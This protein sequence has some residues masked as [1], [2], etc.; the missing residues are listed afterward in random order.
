M[1]RNFDAHTFIHKMMLAWVKD[2]SALGG[3]PA[4]SFAIVAL[5]ALGKISLA[6]YLLAAFIIGLLIAFAIR[7]LFPRER[8]DS[9]L[10]KGN[11]LE[12]LDSSSFPSVHSF[13]AT[14]LGCLFYASSPSYATLAAA[15]ILI[16]AV[17]YARV[18]IKRHHKS[19]VIGGI[20]LGFLVT[21]GLLRFSLWM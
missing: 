4:Y 19:D 8:P 9:K 14:T 18:S 12:R 2:L 20:V 21:V 1:C 6:A 3:L 11:I 16:A 5:L 7:F 10:S 13:R 17:S 15:I